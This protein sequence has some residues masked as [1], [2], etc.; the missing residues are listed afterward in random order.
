MNKS[1]FRA[2]GVG[3]LFIFAYYAYQI[4]WGMIITFRYAPDFANTTGSVGNGQS[5]VAFGQAASNW[6]ISLELIGM[7]ALG[8]SIYYLVR[9]FKKGK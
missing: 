1:I 5:K 4:S 7:M 3:T 6:Q 8:M 9:Y 2:L